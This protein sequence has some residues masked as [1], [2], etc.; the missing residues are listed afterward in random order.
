LNSGHNGQVLAGRGK[1]GK[2]EFLGGRACAGGG[3][4]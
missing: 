4:R 3:S 1:S 2:S